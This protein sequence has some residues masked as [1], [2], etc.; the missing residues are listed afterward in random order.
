MKRS[1]IFKNLV[2]I[3]LVS[4]VVFL[5]S[6]VKNRNDG[7]VDFSQLSPIMQIPEGGLKN[8]STS[9]LVFP[10]SDPVDTAVFHANYA[11]TTVAPSDIAVTF[12]IDDAARLA[13]NAS[14]TDQYLALPA[15]FYNIPT[16]TTVVKAGQSYS[17]ALK[18]AVY[19]IMFDP[20]KSYMLPITI[21]SASGVNISGNFGTIYFH[22]I[23]N[24][25]AGNYQDY[26]QRTNYTG[27]VTLTPPP[28]GLPLATAPGVPSFTYPAGGTVSNNYNQITAFS[29]VSAVT[30]SGTIG[31]VPDPAGGSALYLISGGDPAFS[32]ITY[33]FGATWYNSGSGTGYSN[34]ERFVRAYVAPSPTQKP[35]FRLITHYNNALAGAGNDRIIDESFTHL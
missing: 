17:A 3:V 5:A 28:V 32:F 6:C 2:A 9:A 13:Y 1:I 30:V 29:P 20:S 31:N 11:A 23:G 21:S 27:S 33:D 35:A 16:L 14:H 19:P 18:L 25:L 15:A 24:P 34:T 12:I 4:S 26:G 8:F 22:V 10:A 7:A